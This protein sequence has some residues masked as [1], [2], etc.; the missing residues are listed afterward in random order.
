M[1]SPNCKSIKEEYK[2]SSG[3]VKKLIPNLQD[4]ENYILH[5][6]N[7]ELYLSLGL[8][9]KKVHR[10]LRFKEK[11]WLKDYIDFNT[12]K[13]KNAKNDFKK[14]HY[15]LMNNA[16]F[17]KTIENVRKRCNVYLETDPDHF[18]R[19]TAKPTFKGCK[20]IDENLVVVT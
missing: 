3:N 5:E 20:I 4:K 6:K 19:Q 11:P 8:K 12:E 17:G 18:L 1:L 16:V 10:A 15:K 9:L 14:T 13:R 2:I 7:L